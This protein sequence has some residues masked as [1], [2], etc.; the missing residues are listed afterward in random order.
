MSLPCCCL[1]WCLGVVLLHKCLYGV[2]VYTGVRVL[3]LC[4]SVFPVLFFALVLSVVLLHECLFGVIVCPG[5]QLLLCIPE[6]MVSAF[7]L[8]FRC[9]PSA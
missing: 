3:S 5:G 2:A 7:A 6:F 9:C 4:M 1:R 8:V